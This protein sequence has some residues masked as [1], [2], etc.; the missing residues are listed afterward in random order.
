MA[1][2]EQNKLPDP[3]ENRRSMGRLCIFMGKFIDFIGTRI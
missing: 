3:L 1:R 2:Q